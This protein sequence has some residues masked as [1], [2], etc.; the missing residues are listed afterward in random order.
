MPFGLCN[1]P[2][3]FERLVETL[4]GPH[5]SC[6]MYLDNVIVIGPTFQEHLLNLQ[7]VFQQFQ[8]ACLKLNPKKCQLFQK[9]IWHLGHIVSPEGITTDPEKPKAV[10]EWP[11][12]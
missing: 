6:L 7:K 11:E 10:Q 5:E 1:A 9:E 12:E 2:A 4:K 8:E 3:T